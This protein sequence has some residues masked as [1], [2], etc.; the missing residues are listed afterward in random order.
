MIHVSIIFL[1]VHVWGEKLFSKIDSNFAFES[2]AH[3]YAP[4]Y[5]VVNSRISYA[6]GCSVKAVSKFL[7]LLFMTLPPNQCKI[8]ES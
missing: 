7:V 3:D 6:I 8:T 4:Y 2:C 1:Y 5:H